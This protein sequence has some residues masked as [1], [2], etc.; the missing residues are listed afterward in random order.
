MMNTWLVLRVIILTPEGRHIVQHVTPGVSSMVP[1]DGDI[2]AYEDW[3]GHWRWNDDAGR[4]AVLEVEARNHPA[5][6]QE[7]CG[8]E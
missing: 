8:S 3:P 5:R 4:N 6:Q 2:V 1:E 7:A